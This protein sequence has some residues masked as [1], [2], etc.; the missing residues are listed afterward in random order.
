MNFHQFWSPLEPQNDGFSWMKNKVFDKIKVGEQ[1]VFGMFFLN[2]FGILS[3]V[4]SHIRRGFFCVNVCINFVMNF[5]SILAPFGLHFGFR[6][7]AGPSNRQTSHFVPPT[8]YL[9]SQ[10]SQN[11]A[12]EGGPTKNHQQSIKQIIFWI[13]FLKNKSV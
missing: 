4:C 11:G 1:V 12:P 9:G 7:T 13:F 8:G 10:G 3:K 5:G 2:L 6:G